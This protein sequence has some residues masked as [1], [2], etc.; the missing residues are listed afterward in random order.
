MIDRD[1]STEASIPVQS[2]VDIMDL[3][4]LA[5][6]WRGKEKINIKTMSQL[7]NWSL[8]LLV[9]TMKDN[10]IESNIQN[11][12]SAYAYM[13]A[14]DLIQESLRERSERKLGT[15]LRFEAMR[16]EGINPKDVDLR[17]FNILHGK[18]SVEPLPERFTQDYQKSVLIQEGIK[19][20][21]QLN[22]KDVPIT[23]KEDVEENSKNIRAL[24]GNKE[25]VISE[26]DKDIVELENQPLDKDFMRRSGNVVK[27]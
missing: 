16:A 14:L 10:G 2:R 21:E 9:K 6:Y 20:F 19:V 8:G 5:E 26:R 12:K 27:E 15:A 13:V 17:G 3:A 22:E 18:R 1:R 7:I 4:F 24:I 23:T 11:I 25:I